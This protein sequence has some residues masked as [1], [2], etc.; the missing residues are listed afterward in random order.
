MAKSATTAELDEV[1]A[2]L[3][4]HE[5][6]SA[7]FANLEKAYCDPNELTQLLVRIRR[8][9]LKESYSKAD[10]IDVAKSLEAA[11]LKLQSLPRWGESRNF[12][13][14]IHADAES[15][16]LH[17]GETL[18]KIAKRIETEFVPTASETA[19]PSRLDRAKIRLVEHVNSHTKNKA[20]WYD[21]QVAF[22]IEAVTERI[23]YKEDAQRLWRKRHMK[24]K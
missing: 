11:G 24:A 19:K 6:A 23:D 3:A 10:L 12:R 15:W 21:K 13:D 5:E 22:L 9:W 18:Q 17:T 2:L 1:Q 20:H 4:A 7:A 8:A 16:F 14:E